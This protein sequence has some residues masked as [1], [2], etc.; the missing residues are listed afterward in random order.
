VVVVLLL[1]QERA[2]RGVAAAAD[3]VRKRY[4]RSAPLSLVRLPHLLLLLLVVLMRLLQ[5]HL[6]LLLLLLQQQLVLLRWRQQH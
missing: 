3:A 4:G 6:Q 2:A 5:K 1:T